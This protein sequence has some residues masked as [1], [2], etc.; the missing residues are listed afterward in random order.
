M[1]YPLS[2][3]PPGPPGPAPA[4]KV[5]VADTSSPE[6]GQSGGQSG[7]LSG[8]PAGQPTPTASKPEEGLLSAANRKPLA[9]GAISGGALVIGLTQLFTLMERTPWT[10]KEVHQ[11]LER[12]VE[13]LETRLEAATAVTAA[14]P[15]R[16]SAMEEALRD[17]RGEVRELR[18]FASGGGGAAAGRRAPDSPS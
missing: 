7:G 12:R 8:Q 2:P 1:P 4:T 13:L 10:S 15:V 17:L 16:L 14:V 11:A 18:R 9:V 6:S 5:D 3:T